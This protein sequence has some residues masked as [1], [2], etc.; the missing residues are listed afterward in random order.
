MAV[1]FTK[2]YA[3]APVTTQ[4]SDIA[5]RITGR[6]GLAIPSL[7]SLPRGMRPIEPGYVQTVSRYRTGGQRHGR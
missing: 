6:S 3:D 4:G 2:A 1:P 7:A 5:T